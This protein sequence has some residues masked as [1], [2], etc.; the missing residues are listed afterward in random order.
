MIGNFLGR[1]RHD[2]TDKRLMIPVIFDVGFFRPGVPF[3]SE[4]RAA[5][6]AFKT[7]PDAANAGEKINE[8]KLRAVV[9]PCVAV[10]VENVAQRGASE[11]RTVV[12]AFFPSGDCLGGNAEF[13]GEVLLREPL[14]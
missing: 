9:A 2:V 7:E 5:S 13:E 12:L 3:A 4:D 6:D 1:M 11:M 14:P 8:S 10:A